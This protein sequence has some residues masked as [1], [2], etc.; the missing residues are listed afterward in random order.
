MA[1]RFYLARA[2]S[3]SPTR[4][5]SKSW[6]PP[7][8]VAHF[9]SFSGREFDPTFSPD[10]NQIAFIWD[11]VKG[12][13][14][15]IYVKLINAGTPLRLTT[16]PGV[17]HSPAWSPDGR[18]IIYERWDE[19]GRLDIWLYNLKMKKTYPI[20]TNAGEPSWY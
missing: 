8:K 7:I 4:S 12:D 5:S 10:G 15:D 14:F 9:T 16:H 3:E 20:A 19:S 13:N 18:Y 11:G 17:D 2:P 1:V 6:L